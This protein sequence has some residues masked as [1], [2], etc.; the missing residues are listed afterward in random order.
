MLENGLSAG[1]LSMGVDVVFIGPLPTP[2][3]AYVTRSLRADAGIVITASHNA[4]D[5]NGIKFFRAD[6]FKLD[7]T[8][9]QRIEHLVFSGEIEDIR[10][11][12]TA[13]GKAWRV[14]DALG[15]YI[16]YAKASF[17]RGPHPG[18]PSDRDR[19]RQRLGLQVQPVRPART[20]RRGHRSGQHPQRHEHQQ[21]V[22]LHVPGAVPPE[23][24]RT[25]RRHRH[26]PRRRRRPRPA[27]RRARH[28]HRRRRH[29]GRR[30]LGHAPARRPG[31]ENP[32][33]HRHEQR[34]PGRGLPEG[35]RPP[36]PHGCGRQERGR[37]DAPQTATTSA[38]NKAATSSSATTP[39][40]ATAWSPRSRSCAS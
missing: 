14:D 27:L 40:P 15:R 10:P 25:A 31:R 5:D 37:R 33:H 17:P 32:C 22:R 7:D 18:R 20:G 6:G 35:R 24:P 8:I 39:P 36:C 21:G 2:G 3:V 12:A 30:R 38:A 34:R 1:V 23:G 16:E 28:P 29:H 26:R 4:Y 9:E 13:V 11:T 19:L